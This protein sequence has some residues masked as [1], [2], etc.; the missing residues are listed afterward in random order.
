M[1]Y[2]K[3]NYNYFVPYNDKT[4]VYNFFSGYSSLFDS[5]D[6]TNYE[7]ETFTDEEQEE[8]YKRGFLIDQDKDELQELIDT[9]FKENLRNDKKL[10]RIWTTSGCN[11][12][13]FYCFEKDLKVETLND[14]RCDKVIEYISNN[15][16]ENDIITLEWFG[17]EPLLNT[18]AID[19][20]SKAIIQECKN[21]HAKYTSAIISNGSLITPEIIDKMENEWKIRGIQITLD[22]DEEA[23]N[24]IKDYKNPEEHNFNNVIDNIMLMKNR[25]FNVSIRINYTEDNYKNILNLIDYI[26]PK[27]QDAKNINAYVYPIWSTLNEL[28]ENKFIS[29]VQADD[30]V[31]DIFE[32]I[33]KYNLNK[34]K[35]IIRISKKCS[36]C[37]SCNKNSCAILPNGDI[38]KCSE[39]FH[40]LYGNVNDGIL[41]K[42]GFISWS[43]REIDKKCKDCIYLPICQGGCEASKYTEMPQCFAYKPIIDDILIWYINKLQHK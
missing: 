18:S 28:S 12:R 19:K 8:L 34:R 5:N 14:E 31:L 24:K 36:S 27:V 22:G 20:I 21:K 33:I 15:I 3:S 26:G 25:K 2:K 30:N 23:Y 35:N 42:E 13:C 17:G 1:K 16:N 7:N 9:R 38:S 39:S 11:A 32:A 6:I 43:N 29:N 40:Q 10:Y 4:I 37:R 41:D